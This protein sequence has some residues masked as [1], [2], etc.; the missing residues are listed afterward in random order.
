MKVVNLTPHAVNVLAADGET[1]LEYPPSGV[2]A[3]VTELE[4]DGISG[5]PFAA[6]FPS[7]YG[8]LVNLPEFTAD[9]EAVYIV[10]GLVA[11][12]VSNRPDVFCPGDAIRDSNGRIT[13]V[14]Y[15]KCAANMRNWR[16]G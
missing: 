8:A 4:G 2:V 7:N 1:M 6:R 12:A 15:L 11:A 10:S 14:R 13:G 9:H 16:L 3:R 5:L